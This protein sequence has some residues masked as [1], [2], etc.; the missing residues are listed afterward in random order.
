[1][2]ARPVF[3]VLT[4]VAMA[5]A[6]CGKPSATTAAPADTSHPV[7]VI[8]AAT[9]P[10]TATIT[11]PG[12][13]EAAETVQVAAMIAGAITAV[14]VREGQ[15][16]AAGAHVALIDPARFAIAVDQARAQVRVVEAQEAE[17]RADLL[18]ADEL[19]KTPGLIRPDQLDQLKARAAQ[20]AAGVDRAKADLAAAELD[21]TRATAVAPCAGTILAR[22]AQLGMWAQPGAALATILPEGSLRLRASVPAVEAALL[23]SGQAVSFTVEGDEIVR[24]ANIT[25][26]APAAD[27]QTRQVEILAEPVPGSAA[28]LRANTFARLTIAVAA[29]RTVVVLPDLSVRP[30]E[31]GFLAYVVIDGPQGPV[32]QERKLVIGQRTSDGVE[33]RSGLVAGERVAVRGAEALRD[34]AR[35]RILAGN[36]P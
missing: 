7:E 9:Q 36:Q 25:S 22:P 3:M 19:A 21:L 16:V 31:R 1:M 8:T 6:G 18:R 12:R 34:G 2:Y 29:E 14:P 17:V 30:G 33:V 4:T 24:A 20:S 10:L 28:G 27:A 26:V 15:R 35:V 23:T 11:A 5:L 13:I 32:A